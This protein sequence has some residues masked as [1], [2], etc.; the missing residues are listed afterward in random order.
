[1]FPGI[2]HGVSNQ[3]AD[4]VTLLIRLRAEDALAARENNR[5]AGKQDWMWGD[6]IAYS[7]ICTHAGCPPA[8]TSSRPT[9]CSA[10]ATSPSS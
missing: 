9:G 6:F 3:Y 4:S 5:R 8:S 2:P 1:M 7:K 10:R